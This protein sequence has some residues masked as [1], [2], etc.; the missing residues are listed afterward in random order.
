[1]AHDVADALAGL[2]FPAWARAVVRAAGI[3]PQAGDG[4]E[5]VAIAGVDGDPFSLAFFTVFEVAA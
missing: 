1:M 4:H 5:D 3:Q 2:R